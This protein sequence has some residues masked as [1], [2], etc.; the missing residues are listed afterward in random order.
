MDGREGVESYRF[1]DVVSLWA[2]ERLL[3]E[4]VIARELAAGF[5]R[6]GL[7]LHSRDPRWLSGGAGAVE[8]RGYPFVGYSALPGQPPVVIRASALEHLLAIVNSGQEPDPR[9]LHEEFITR[10]EFLDWL[11]SAGLPAPQ[12]W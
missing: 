7:R 11:A 8:F 4:V 1:W 3:H 5:V 10:R 9:R 6:G 2:R 12:F